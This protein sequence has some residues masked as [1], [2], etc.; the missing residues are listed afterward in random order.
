M[1][2][3]VEILN[4]KATKLLR[5]LADMKLI[6]ITTQKDN[7]FISLLNRLRSKEKS[8]PTLAEITREVEAVRKKRHAR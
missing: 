1:T 8:A 7:K 5:D 2:L 3:Q 6:S 4:P